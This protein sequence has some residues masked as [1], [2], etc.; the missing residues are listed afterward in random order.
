MITCFFGITGHV[1]TV[2][3]EQR[4]TVNSEC[5]NSI[6]AL[7]V[8]WEIWKKQKKRRITLTHRL[9]QKIFWNE[10]NTPYSPDLAPNDFFFYSRIS[11]INYVDND[12]RLPKKRLMHLK[13]TI[14]SYLIRNGES[15]SKI[16]SNV[17]KRIDLHGDYSEKQ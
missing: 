9:K 15:A 11:I 8:V 4:R 12:F 1:V 17:Q 13:R 2:T 16:G 14:S 3:L 10:N 7:E 5:Y 6:C